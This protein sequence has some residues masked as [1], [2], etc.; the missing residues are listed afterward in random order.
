MLELAWRFG[1]SVGSV[2]T[3]EPEQIRTIQANRT[4]PPSV[5]LEKVRKEDRV[6]VRRRALESAAIEGDSPV[7]QKPD[8]I[9][10]VPE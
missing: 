4:S 1:N 8:R 3:N 9:Q 10:G 6:L 2:S 7:F 5:E